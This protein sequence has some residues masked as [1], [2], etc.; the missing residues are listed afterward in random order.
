MIISQ[1]KVVNNFFDQTFLRESQ[2]KLAKI[3]SFTFLNMIFQSGLE[4]S[5]IPQSSIHHI[6]IFASIAYFF[7]SKNC[8]AFFGLFA[9]P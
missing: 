4:Y 2:K 7:L 6:F 8:Q 3:I 5:T 1:A 9:L